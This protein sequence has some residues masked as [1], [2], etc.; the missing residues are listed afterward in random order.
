MKWG[1]IFTKIGAYAA[2]ATS[3]G[4]FV[5][6]G[7]FAASHFGIITI[8]ISIPIAL[9]AGGT[10]TFCASIGLAAAETVNYIINRRSEKRKRDTK[11]RLDDAR[12]RLVNTNAKI[13]EY[14]KNLKHIKT[15]NEKLEKER[16]QRRNDNKEAQKYIDKL[17]DENRKL[18]QTQYDDEENETDDMSD[19]KEFS[20]ASNDEMRSTLKFRKI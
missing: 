1:R 2:F 17:V 5:G 15:K 3:V 16:E 20:T 8:P 10:A 7:L 18:R 13:L 4:L 6:S 9:A 11:K 14:D 19:E 12:A